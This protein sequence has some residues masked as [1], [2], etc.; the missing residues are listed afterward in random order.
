MS[1]RA[2]RS[3][4]AAV[5]AFDLVCLVVFIGNAASSASARSHH[6]PSLV[7]IAASLPMRLIVC[8]VGVA[9]AWRFARRANALA[10][11][12][13]VLMALAFLSTVHA[14]IFGSPWRH[15]YFSGACLLGWLLGLEISR[16]REGA[17][18]EG[19]AHV[20]AVTLLGAAY[21]NS[22]LSKLVFGGAEWLSGSVIQAIVV[23]QDGLA[24]GGWLSGYRIATANAP[25]WARICCIATVVLELAG[26]AL[27]GRAIVRIPAALGLFAM[28]LNIFLLTDIP[29]LESM[30]L[31]LVL[32][33]FAGDS[34]AAFPSERPASPAYRRSVIAAAVLCAIAVYHQGSR[35]AEDARRRAAANPITAVDSLP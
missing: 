3:W 20:G 6:V 22:G 4:L 7:T 9:A 2:L 33:V 31:L 1:H 12:V 5:A 26:P 30:T 10:A 16:R 13:V 25:G 27:V 23:G 28:H 18:S 35:F 19:L 17:A 24:P 34:A 21:F 29:Y 15:L 32:G 8:G 14:Q 11:G